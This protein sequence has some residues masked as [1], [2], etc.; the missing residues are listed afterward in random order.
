ML[1]VSPVAELDNGIWRQLLRAL[2]VIPT[3]SNPREPI[4]DLKTD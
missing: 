1:G 2:Q 4:W 3:P